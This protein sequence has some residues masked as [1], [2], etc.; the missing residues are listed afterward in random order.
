MLQ[1]VLQY[2]VTARG[3]AVTRMP[4]GAN[5]NFTFQAL[6]IFFLHFHTVL[7]AEILFMIVNRRALLINKMSGQS[8]H[9]FIICKPTYF[10]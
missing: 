9:F 10:W 4:C 5:L 7:G 3:A 8:D 6:P 2:R 1:Y